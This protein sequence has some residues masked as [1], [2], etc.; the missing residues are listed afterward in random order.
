MSFRSG[1]FF[2]A[3][4]TTFGLRFRNSHCIIIHRPSHL[5]ESI[6]WGEV[7]V[8]GSP[9][10]IITFWLTPLRNIHIRGFH[11][12]SVSVYF[13]GLEG[14]SHVALLLFPLHSQ[15]LLLF[16]FHEGGS[17]LTLAQGILPRLF[18]FIRPSVGCWIPPY[19]CRLRSFIPLCFIFISLVL[20]DDALAR[21]NGYTFAGFL[22][23]LGRLLYSV[24]YLGIY[25]SI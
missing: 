25:G 24:R 9:E 18:T 17:Y 14:V 1:S 5:R 8:A 11:S 6:I 2:G 20:I 7:T 15:S 10:H 3:W 12:H 22:H 13:L 4:E 16:R 19:V 21:M 23:I